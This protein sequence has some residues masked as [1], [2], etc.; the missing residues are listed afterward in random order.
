MEDPQ[1]MLNIPSLCQ[2]FVHQP[3]EMAHTQF[4]QSIIYH[5]MD[6]SLFAAFDTDTF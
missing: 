5:Y 2:Y 1:V 4:I 6:H 3:L